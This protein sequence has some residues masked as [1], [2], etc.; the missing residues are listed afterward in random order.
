MRRYS[1]SCG[2]ML[3]VAL[4][5]ALLLIGSPRTIAQAPPQGGPPP[6][7]TPP[8]PPKPGPVQLDIQDGSAASY[9]VTEQLAGVNFPSDAIGTTP[10]VTGSIALNADGTVNSAASKLTID[11]RMLKSDQD[12]RDGYIQRR[13]LETDKF[14]T[15]VFVPKTLTGVASPFPN[16]GQAGFQLAGDLTVH[17]TTAPVTWQGIVTFNEGGAS[18]RGAT[19]FTFATFGLTKPTLARILSVDDKINLDV[20]FKFKTTRE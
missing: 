7:F 2:K 19:S 6:G 4:A 1:K 3:S 14:P 16:R 8:P 9:R 15:A 20:I 12:M 13:T 10:A 5:A 11:L 18:G 17:G